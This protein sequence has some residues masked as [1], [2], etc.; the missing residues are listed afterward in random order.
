MIVE[1]N[2]ILSTSQP[3]QTTESLLNSFPGRPPPIQQPW[4]ELSLNATAR[5]AESECTLNALSAPPSGYGDSSSSS[6]GYATGGGDDGGG[7]ACCGDAASAAWPL[8][9]ELPKEDFNLKGF[10][11]EQKDSL[12]ADEPNEA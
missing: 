3:T 5:A 8:Q 4:P 12:E 10:P 11:E 2:V 1:S 6:Y 9:V 7:G